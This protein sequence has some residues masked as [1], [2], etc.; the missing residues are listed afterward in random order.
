[1]NTPNHSHQSP[2]RQRFQHKEYGQF[3]DGENPLIFRT[4]GDVV[5][6][7]DN[8]NHKYTRS[9][10]NPVGSDFVIVKTISGNSYGVGRGIVLNKNRGSAQVLPHDIP[11]IVI[12]EP[13]IVP[14]VGSTT[15]IE[16]V[17]VRWMAGMGNH[18]H[19][20][21]LEEPNPFP[22][23]EEALYEAQGTIGSNPF[24]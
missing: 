17:L 3:S 23:L 12:G 9:V 1:M 22:A 5:A 4:P 24:K 8:S 7:G 21:R 20:V 2:E 13:W 16:S 10:G 18:Y 11:D 6:L 14:G 15:S 19:T